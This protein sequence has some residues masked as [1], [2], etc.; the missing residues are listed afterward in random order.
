ME[1]S[2]SLEDARPLATQEFPKISWDH[3]VYYHV[4]KGL[5]LVPLLSQMNPVHIT[6]SYSSKINGS[7]V[8]PPSCRSS[9]LYHSLWLSHR[10]PT[11]IHFLHLIFPLVY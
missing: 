6:P 7:N 4:H 5:P 1:L 10:N 8:L 2:P 11:C 3:K 9:W